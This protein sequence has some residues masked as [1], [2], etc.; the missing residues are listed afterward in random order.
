MRTP[1]LS[2]AVLATVLFPAPSIFA[3]EKIRLSVTN[4]NVSFLPAGVALKKGFFKDEGFDAEVIR[5][6]VPNAITALVTGDVSYTLIF[7]SVV[8]GA[9][10]GMPMRVVASFLDSSTH[11][12]IARP[13]YK[14]VKDLKGKTVG[15]GNFGGTDDVAG[16]FMLR[17]GGL[18]PEKEVKMIALGPDRARLAGLKEGLVDAVIVAPPA[19][20][21]GREMGFAVVM[22]AYEA[23]RLPFIGLGTNLK[24]LKEKP[25]EVKKILKALVKANRFI[26]ENKDGAVQVLSEWARVE[27]AHAAAAYDGAVQVFSRDGT[28]PEDGLKLVIDQAKA[29]LKLTR[30][31]SFAE[32]ADF[33]VLREAQRELG[34]KPR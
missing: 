16:R 14:S 5:M 22:R 28:I 2:V 7:G 8:R 1:I 15:I 32:V 27:R 21:L 33:A 13:D 24:Q 34:L 23:F 12:L 29:D 4:A 26:R 17:H 31:V 11:A 18:D 6:N 3:A 20:A 10:R 9:L 19:D 30:E 25:E